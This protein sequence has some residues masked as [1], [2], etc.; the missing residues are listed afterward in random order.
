MADVQVVRIP[1]EVLTRITGK[2]SD[3]IP[4]IPYVGA[5][6]GKV[7]ACGGLAFHDERWWLFLEVYGGSRTHPAYVVRWGR[8]MLRKAVQLDLGAVYAAMDTAAEAPRAP[9]LLKALGFVCKGPEE[10]AAG[11]RDIWVWGGA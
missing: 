6:D 11:V 9:K 5:E 2:A 3:D 1:P 8:L 4:L 7:I 10:V